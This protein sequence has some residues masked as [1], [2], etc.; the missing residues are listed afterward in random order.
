MQFHYEEIIRFVKA[1]EPCF[2]AS[3]IED[4]ET[5]KVFDIIRRFRE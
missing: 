3:N 2:G 5:P 1:I 4:I